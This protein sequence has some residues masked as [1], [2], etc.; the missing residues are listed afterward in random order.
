LPDRPAPEREPR[1]NPGWSRR[2]SRSETA[3]APDP[4]SDRQSD[5]VRHRTGRLWS[6]HSHF[7]KL[8]VGALRLEIGRAKSTS[9]QVCTMPAMGATHNHGGCAESLR[10]FRISTR[11]QRHRLVRL[12][13]FW[14]NVFPPCQKYAA[15]PSHHRRAHGHP[16]AGASHHPP[17]E[18]RGRSRC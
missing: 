2:L 4:H 14:R 15:R 6:L 13:D 9:A 12:L 8:L 1:T 17:E 7:K 10:H 5:F 16:L 3:F 18:D 11:R